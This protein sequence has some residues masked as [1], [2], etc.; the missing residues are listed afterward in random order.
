[1]VRRDQGIAR[2]SLHAAA[3]SLTLAEAPGY[4]AAMVN[5]I[6]EATPDLRLHAGAPPCAR[7]PA[8][9]LRPTPGA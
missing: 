5:Q 6:P 1:M 3:P 4:D 2:P 8:L 7:R 9:R